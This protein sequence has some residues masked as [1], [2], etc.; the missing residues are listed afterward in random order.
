M[1]LSLPDLCIFHPVD[2][3]LSVNHGE[4]CREFFLFDL[5]ILIDT[6]RSCKEIFSLLYFVDS[7]IYFYWVMN[8][9]GKQ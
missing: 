5:S 2:S 1:L 4:A 7:F 9:S 6:E 3:E 8:K